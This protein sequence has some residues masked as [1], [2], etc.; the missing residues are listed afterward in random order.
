MAYTKQVWQNGETIATAERMKHIEDGI[1]DLYNAIFPVG[2][3]VIKGDNEDYSNWLGFTWERTAVGKVLVGIDSTDT[4]F[5]EIGKTGGEKT[6]TLTI[7]EMP[8][9]QHSTVDICSYSGGNVD[10]KTGYGY[11][12]IKLNKSSY[13]NSVSSTGGGQSH[14]NLQPYQVVAYWKRIA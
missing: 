5:N 6:H 11:E 7:N 10:Q 4:D 12:E 1:A 3:I 2:Q 9:H 14:N 13:G 8:S